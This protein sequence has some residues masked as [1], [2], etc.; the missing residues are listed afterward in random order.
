[1]AHLSGREQIEGFFVIAHY[2]SLSRLCSRCKES[3]LEQYVA[4]V[5]GS[6]WPDNND[7]GRRPFQ[8][9]L[10]QRVHA[11]G[12]TSVDAELLLLRYENPHGFDARVDQWETVV[13]MP[14][15]R[16]SPCQ[17]AELAA[18]LRF[19]CEGQFNLE[20]LYAQRRIR[21]FVGATTERLILSADPLHGRKCSCPDRHWAAGR[22]VARVSA[23]EFAGIV[24]QAAQREMHEKI[25]EAVR[26]GR[27]RKAEEGRGRQRK[28][29]EVCVC[30]Y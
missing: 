11:N 30:V 5:S 29:E 14:T 20:D 23:H 17:A 22:N 13:R 28:A 15:D 16:Y 9:L 27:Q 25:R 24:I 6:C 1:M 3:I 10:A 7:T 2:A 18:K 4:S 8:R 21:G 19:A 12:R 26:R